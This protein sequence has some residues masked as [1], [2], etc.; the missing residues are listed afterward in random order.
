V[1]EQEKNASIEYILSQGLVKPQSTRERITEM[2]RQV[3]FRF[4]F[5]DMGYGLFFALLSLAAVIALFGLTPDNYHRSAAV[6]CAPMLFLLITAFSEMSER[7]LGLFELKQTCR[8]TV[9][10]I[11]TLRVICYSFAG[12][13][14]TIIITAVSVAGVYEFFSLFPLCLSALFLCAVLEISVMR[15]VRGRWASAV[16]SAVWTLVNILLPLSLGQAWENLLRGTPLAASV[17]LAAASI[18]VFGY[19]ISKMLSEGK[20]YAVA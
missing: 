9:T 20:K 6:A 8:Y 2:I 7:A 12:T 13:V 16:Y 15:A 3:G 4:I 5:W 18:L 19:Q 17:A 1:N 10:Q 14:F 11:S